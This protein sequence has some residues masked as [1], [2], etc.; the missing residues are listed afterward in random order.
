MSDTLAG[1]YVQIDRI[2]IDRIRDSGVVCRI[3]RAAKHEAKP[4]VAVGS[5]RYPA[6]R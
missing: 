2:H 1:D 5:E 6:N 4:G 3:D